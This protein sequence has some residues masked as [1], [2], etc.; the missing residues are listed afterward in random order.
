MFGSAEGA[1]S[2][3]RAN[4]SSLTFA[5]TVAQNYRLA[6]AFS[7]TASRK[8]SIEEETT[9]PA[10]AQSLRI[11]F[12]LDNLASDPYTCYQVL[13]PRRLGLVFFPHTLLSQA[14]QTI[15]LFGYTN[16]PVSHQCTSDDLLSTD[17]A[18]VLDDLLV[19]AAAFFGGCEFIHR[20]AIAL[21]LLIKFYR[22]TLCPAVKRQLGNLVVG[23]SVARL[24]SYQ[25]VPSLFRPLRP[26]RLIFSCRDSNPFIVHLAW[27]GQH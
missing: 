23:T 20:P 10:F 14:N 11:R 2:T 16:H 19:E 12:N 24:R 15:Q 8:K 3:G 17:K 9:G 7:A 21:V 22:E 1:R 18:K 6:P 26:L 27:R 25:G 13:E 4:P 5:H